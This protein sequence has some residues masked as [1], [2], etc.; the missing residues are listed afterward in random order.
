MQGPSTYC[1]NPFAPAAVVEL[2]LMSD[3][4]NHSAEFQMC[5]LSITGKRKGLLLR[6]AEKSPPRPAARC[7]AVFGTHNS[8]LCNAYLG[9]MGRHAVFIKYLRKAGT[10][11][12]TCL[13]P[14][15]DATTAWAVLWLFQT[16][17]QLDMNVTRLG[18][19]ST[20]LHG[21]LDLAG[22]YLCPA[23]G[24]R[25]L[26]PYPNPR[27]VLRVGERGTTSGRQSRLT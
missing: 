3:A 13:L 22:C 2:C 8:P 1:K 27:L 21:V 25:C 17:A 11:K 23:Q 16:P 20:W 19:V 15:E 7:R 14:C 9:Q 6:C 24:V 12:H 18:W 4:S 5:F 26:R 10:P